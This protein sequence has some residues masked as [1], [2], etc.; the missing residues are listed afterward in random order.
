MHTNDFTKPAFSKYDCLG[1]WGGVKVKNFVSRALPLEIGK[2][3]ALGTSLE[4]V[5]V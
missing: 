2:G 5:D 3:E 1:F 4:I